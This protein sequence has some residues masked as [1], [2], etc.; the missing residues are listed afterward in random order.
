MADNQFQSVV[1][2]LMEG[3][4]GVL[5]SKTV[6]GEPITIGDTILIPL[7]DVTIG[8]GGGVSSTGSGARKDSGMGGFS[9]K[10]SP[11]AVLIIKGGNTKVVN[12]KDSNTLSRLVDM[13]PEAIDKVI[14][15]KNGK[16]MMSDEEAVDLAFGGNET[17]GSPE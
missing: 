2:S 9:A 4:D 15:A 17:N 7:N 1:R 12:I 8:C 13:I 11:S 5:S 14:A 3:A 6:V 16:D 10:L